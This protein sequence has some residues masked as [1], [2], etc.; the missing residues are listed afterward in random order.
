MCE[1]NNDM[2]MKSKLVMW[3]DIGLL[4]YIGD[5]ENI[6][7]PSFD[8]FEYR[9]SVDIIMIPLDDEMLKSRDHEKHLGYHWHEHIP[10]P[11]IEVLPIEELTD[12]EKSDYFAFVQFWKQR[13]QS[14]L[15]YHVGNIP[16]E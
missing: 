3:D 12:E 1:S 13:E 6:Y 11:N 2:D 4:D 15:C 8:G 14:G 7:I 5:V 10:G 16:I 9:D